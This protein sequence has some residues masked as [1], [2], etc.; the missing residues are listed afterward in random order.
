[1]QSMDSKYWNKL[2]FLITAAAIIFAANSCIESVPVNLPPLVTVEEATDI[3]RTGASVIGNIQLQGEGDITSVQ[4]AWGSSP[5]QMDNIIQLDINNLSP[6]VRLTGLAAGTQYYYCLRAGNKYTLIE[7][8]IGSFTTNPNVKPSLDKTEILYS[9]L[10]SCTAG[11]RITDNGGKEV[12]SAGFIY[13]KKGEPE[14]SGVRVE[15]EEIDPQGFFYCKIEVLD[16]NTEYFVQAFARQS[17]GE[18]LGNTAE[19]KTGAPTLYVPTAGMLK[20]ILSVQEGQKI[21]QASVGG[22]LNGNDIRYLRDLLIRE[23]N[24]SG[25]ALQH[26]NLSEV[27]IVEGGA[28]YDGM[29]YT[30]NDTISTNMFGN[31]T[32]LKTLILPKDTRAVMEN[33]FMGCKSLEYV[34]IPQYTAFIGHSYGCASLE[35]F[36]VSNLNRH[37]SSSNGILLNKAGNTLLWFPNAAYG[38]STATIPAGVTKIGGYAFAECPLESVSLGNE[39]TEI[40]K[41]AF[42]NSAIKEISLPDKIQ[43]IPTGLF[44]NSKSL[45]IVRLG[46]QT[47]YISDYFIDGTPIE[48]L[49]IYA[50]TFTPYCSK[51]AFSGIDTNKCTVYVKRG[52]LKLY[53]NS[54]I[55]ETFK[56]ITEF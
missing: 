23:D 26:L 15:A 47:D 5:L 17:I 55:G 4:F 51:N 50:E 25:G 54:I 38:N 19:F 28:S 40:G 7:S 41:F 21:E 27:H 1:M 22:Y 24:T 10:I 34:Y 37:F 14:S 42:I 9:G 44:Q 49:Y 45:K 30:K 56:N 3:T 52:S 12:T 2:F 36:E 46:A 6:Q 33:A 8:N 35:E 48:E 16:E 31:F 39:I 32:R 18:G 43:T 29:R 20:E 13:W 11:C 53:K